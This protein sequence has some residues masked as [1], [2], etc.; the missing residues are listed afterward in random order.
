MTVAPSRKVMW[1]D[2]GSNPQPR[3]HEG[4]TCT[5]DTF[6][7]KIHWLPMLFN[8]LILNQSLFLDKF[9]STI[10]QLIRIFTCFN[11]HTPKSHIGK[12]RNDLNRRYTSL[13]KIR[14]QLRKPIKLSAKW[15]LD[16]CI[17]YMIKMQFWQNIYNGKTTN[18]KK[19]K[20]KCHKTE[21]CKVK[22][23]IAVNYKAIRTSKPPPS[24]SQSLN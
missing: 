2:W 17:N 20:K 7:A 10:S 18:K 22:N 1:P 21:Q 3:K 12:K 6:K 23:I 11:E 24:D 5:D 19:K 13:N 15:A 4:I 16:A 14:F 9:F 8:I